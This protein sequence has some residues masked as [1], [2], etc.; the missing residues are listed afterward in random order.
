[1]DLRF[2]VESIPHIV[3]MSAPDGSIEY[4]NRWGIEYTGFSPEADA[5]WAWAWLVHPDDAD[6]ARRAWEQATRTEAPYEAEYRIRRADG[7]FDCGDEPADAVA[8]AR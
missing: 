5:G 3:W 4:F 7:Q 2:I 8:S 1:M 6:P